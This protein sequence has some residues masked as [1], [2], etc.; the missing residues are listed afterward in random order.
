[1]V[2]ENGCEFMNKDGAMT[3]GPIWKKMCFFALPLFLGNLFQQLYN[4]V[5]SLIVGRTVGKSA[6]AAVS[7]SGNIIFLLI[8]FLSG[9]SVGAGVVVAKYF[10]AKDKENLTKSVHTTVAFGLVASLLLTVVGTILTPTILKLMDTPISAFEDSRKYL[11]I[12]FM[13]ATGA[14]M[15]NIFV[16]ILQAI[17]D[18]RHPLYYL[19][20]SSIT[21]VIL[22]LVFIMTFK[23]GVSGA[24]LATIISQFL[25]SSL[26]LIQLMR[27]QG[28]YRL[29][30][31]MI[32]FDKTLLKEIIRYG[33]P[34]GLQNSVIALA[35]VVVQ[36]K[37]NFFGEQAMA[38]VGAY[39]K[40][41]G[42][43][44]L[45]I[46][47]FTMAITT[48]VSQ[49][50]GAK[51][52]E[53]VQKGVRFGVLITILLAEMIGVLIF[54]FAP[55]LIALFN[56]DEEVV[57]FGVQ[58]ARTSALFYF[59]LAYSHALSAVL[60]GSGKSIVPMFVMLICWCVIRVLFL[61]IMIPIFPN[62]DVVYWVYP[63]T[64]SL[65]SI[66]FLVYYRLKTK[67]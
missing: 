67:Y 1:M 57:H 36:S 49:N 47:S 52:Y 30:I 32:R 56:E 4:T 50:I 61:V 54:V 7:S 5:D 28:D 16:G 6:L 27:S 23:M 14:V 20:I 17:G 24:A 38:G 26:C 15:Y 46:T 21:N 59:L 43:G 65:S 45:P 3:S 39:S 10:G 19:V 51:E 34:S 29:V 18:S 35:N 58:K 9:I 8:G 11:Q 64:W 66:Y 55:S 60:R 40:I 42:F 2:F 13:G 53:R 37:V 33:L 25:S 22:D 63:L 48:F 31:R 41:E 62:I 12:Y 44:F